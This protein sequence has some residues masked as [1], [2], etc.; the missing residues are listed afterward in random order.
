PRQVELGLRPERA[1]V[2]TD[3]LAHPDDFEIVR[4]ALAELGWHKRVP[5]TSP[6]VLPFHSVALAHEGWP[7]EI[8]LHHHFPG[9]FADDAAAFEALWRRR[10][11]H[12]VAGREVAVCDLAGDTLIAALHAARAPVQKH[13][14]MEFLIE[15]VR[16]R[17]SPADL[18]DLATLAAETGSADTLRTFLD[19]VGAPQFGAGATG[20]DHLAAWS[21]LTTSE[22]IRG[23]GWVDALRHAPWRERLGLLKRA[24]FL[25][26][27]E[28]RDQ[29]PQAPAGAWGLLRAHVW[30]WRATASHLPKAIKAQRTSRARGAGIDR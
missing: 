1:S 8:D 17:F 30:R 19:A 24:V 22:Q 27:A 14:D 9:F 4:S 16:G 20:A 29:Y 21:L 2:D 18:H 10:R 23:I 15:S 25:S 13:G 26:E 6:H 28:L 12:L 7:C 5:D 11:G 3:A